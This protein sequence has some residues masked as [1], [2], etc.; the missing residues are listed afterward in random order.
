MKGQQCSVDGNCTANNENSEEYVKRTDVEFQKLGVMGI[1]MLAASGDDG[2]E[3][4]RKCDEMRPDYPASSVYVTSVGATS[5]T[6]S[7]DTY[8]IGSDAPPV[9]T[10]SKYN[11]ACSTSNSEEAAMKTNNAGFDSGGGF[12][13]WLLRPD[14]Q[15]KAVT[16]YFKS[17][18][19]LPSQQYWNSTNR[20]YPDVAAVGAEVL[21]IKNGRS[22]KVG[23]TSASTPIWG[24]LITLLNNDRLNSGKSPLGF[25]NPLL[26]KMWQ[27]QPN[28]FIDITVGTNGGGCS[29]LAFQATKGWDP[30]TGLGTPNF[31]QIR[32]YVAKLP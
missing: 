4:D 30:L 17:G 8:P 21:I 18:V 26:Y 27:D 1:T 6:T 24:G 20:G 29:N 28:T 19:T 13:N 23:G 3:S 14:Y 7:K 16:D 32:A 15:Y 9:C 12:S 11:C 31:G 25:V 22:E 10:D 5:V 2:V